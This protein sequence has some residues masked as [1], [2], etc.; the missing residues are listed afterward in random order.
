MS[1]RLASNAQCAKH[2]RSSTETSLSPRW[3]RA[4]DDPAAS[5]SIQVVALK[6][7]PAAMNCLEEELHPLTELAVT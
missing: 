1:E 7:Q 4:A 2:A 5:T 3:R 6:R